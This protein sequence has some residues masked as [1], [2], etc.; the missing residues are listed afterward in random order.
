MSASSTHGLESGFRLKR[1][2]GKKFMDLARDP[3]E[4]PQ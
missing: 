3:P 2:P 1:I 4:K